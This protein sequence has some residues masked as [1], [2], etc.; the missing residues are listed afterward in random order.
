MGSS[1]VVAAI[2]L[3]KHR[4]HSPQAP[5]LSYLT[6]HFHTTTSI[7]PS[8]E[9]HSLK[10]ISVKP[11]KILS[12]YSFIIVLEALRFS[13]CYKLPPSVQPPS[14]LMP[15]ASASEWHTTDSHEFRGLFSTGAQSRTFL[16]CEEDGLTA[17]R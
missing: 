12:Q 2:S 6:S 5:F 13:G 16:F 15:M 9:E 14:Q 17:Q 10:K 1:T 11:S 7:H 8:P 4:H 3:C